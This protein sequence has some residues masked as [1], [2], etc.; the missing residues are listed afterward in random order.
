MQK[1][2]RLI[3]IFLIILLLTGCN[4]TTVKTTDKDI[5]L[6]EPDQI[7]AQTAAV[8]IGSVKKM[9]SYLGTINPK[10]Y[11]LCFQKSGKFL[12]YKVNL[13]DEVN[14]GEVIATTDDTLLEE[15]IEDYQDQLTDLSDL[16]EE[17]LLNMGNSLEIKEMEIE[18]NYHDIEKAVYGTTNYA[19]LCISV[20]NRV[21]DKEKLQLEI[22]QYTAKSQLEIQYLQDK[23]VT[24]TNKLGT[25]QITSPCD[26][27]VVYLADLG[28]GA[29]VDETWFQVVVA[30]STQYLLQGSYINQAKISKMARIYAVKDGVEL[31]LTYLPYSNEEFLSRSAKGETLYTT[32]IIDNPMQTLEFGEN[33]S[34]IAVESEAENV[35]TIPVFSLHQD[36]LGEYVYLYR[37]GE[38]VKKEVVSGIQDGVL[39]EVKEGLKEG[40]VVYVSD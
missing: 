34:I 32:F 5:V 20:G 25:N 16:Y 33:A 9:T 1:V 28:Q 12:E 15:Q 35:L 31:E 29:S 27:T 24:L 36:N 11:N 22:E 30:D 8:T 6:L 14:K 13:G 26:G 23:I 21:L 2:K 3:L 37:D 19:N 40:D 38:K 10:V 4:S 18:D 17:T 7:K 39:A